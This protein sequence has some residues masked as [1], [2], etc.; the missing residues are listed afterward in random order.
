[1]QISDK[2]QSKLSKLI[3]MY[4]RGT[5]HESENAETL[6][7]AIAEKYNLDYE[8][9]FNEE[10][11]DVKEW[12][13]TARKLK[14]EQLITAQCIMRHLNVDTLMWNKHKR[15]YYVTCS[16]LDMMII[17]EMICHYL[18]EWN[19]QKRQLM[20]NACY[21]FMQRHELLGKYNADNDT[22]TAEQK[23]KDY[24]RASQI[25]K[26]ANAMTSKHFVHE[27]NKTKLETNLLDAGK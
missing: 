22:R 7:K 9:L 11:S 18:R 12:V 27:T 4:K 20:E 14:E 26:L 2:L 19:L 25:H 24:E 10:E 1:M 17:V 13:F 15:A 16:G 8:S 21:G 5:T 3:A 6:L 23:A